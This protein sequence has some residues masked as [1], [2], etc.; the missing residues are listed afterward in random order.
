MFTV[1]APT[2]RPA[3]VN[4]VI[5]WGRS[6]PCAFEE[7]SYQPK[8][9]LSPK[10]LANPEMA[11]ESARSAEHA[12]TSGRPMRSL[13]RLLTH[14]PNFAKPS[15]L[16]AF[17]PGS[18]KSSAG[19]SSS[20][21]RSSCMF[22][23]ASSTSPSGF[24]GID[25][26]RPTRVSARYSAS[27]SVSR[28]TLKTVWNQDLDCSRQPSSPVSVV[29]PWPSKVTPYLL[30]NSSRQAQNISELRPWDLPCEAASKTP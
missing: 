24:A 12:R 11:V 9:C 30:A 25:S 13:A 7:R 26:P 18:R 14:A 2:T 21:P 19:S 16:A 22:R 1:A 17:A 29:S 10:F 27:P 6:A 23:A 5:C 20:Q 28:S 15:L 8:F 4:S 3:L